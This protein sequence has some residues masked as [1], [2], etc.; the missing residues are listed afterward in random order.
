[1]NTNQTTV[2]TTTET[3][4]QQDNNN[5]T[6]TVDSNA[7]TASTLNNTTTGASANTANNNASTVNNNTASNN[8]TSDSNANNASANTKSSNAAS[9]VNTKSGTVSN[10]ST[11][12]NNTSANSANSASTVSNVNTSN[13]SNTGKP[14]NEHE[15]KA[16]LW[17][18]IANMAI[19]FIKFIVATITK[20][21]SMM[22]EAVHSFA[23]TFNEIT[24]VLGKKM[25]H[26][27]RSRRHP[28]GT[29]RGRYLASFLVVVLLFVVGG[30]YSAI[31]A[32]SKMISILRGGPEMHA[33]DTSHL[34]IVLIVCVISFC[35]E[36]YSL[37]NSILEAR[38]RY[39][40]TH[41]G[42]PEDFNLWRFWKGTK[43]SDLACVITEDV[44]ACIGLIFAGFGTLTAL[45]TGDDIYDAAGGAAVG[46]LL[47]LG[48]IILGRKIASLLLGEGMSEQTYNRVEKIANEVLSRKLVNNEFVK[49]SDG[50]YEYDANSGN[51]LISVEGLHLDEDRIL[52][53]MKI[54]IK[55]SAHVDDAVI[56]DAIESEVRNNIFWY[57]WEIKIEVDHF[58]PNRVRTYPDAE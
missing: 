56:I 43:S 8:T 30:L 41:S 54:D 45:L 57:D 32:F 33:V 42:K 46:I 13:T 44:L 47:I 27:T 50:K 19:F 3:L 21:A 58:D 1:M 48:A 29:S 20:S 16:I 5:Q 39:V 31:E 28:F 53:T 52:L 24:L 10:V 12:S 37:H 7:S 55:D 26:K 40:I 38:G 17:A 34:I 15:G 22:S 36:S 2:K 14:E 35:L 18:F 11:T 49:T 4:N 6:K 51:R 9:N 25:S 23:D